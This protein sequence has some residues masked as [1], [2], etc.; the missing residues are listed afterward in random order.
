VD[1]VVTGVRRAALV[2]GG[3]L[4]GLWLDKVIVQLP[5]L[6]RIDVVAYAACGRSADLGNGIAFY[7]V[8]GVVPRC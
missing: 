6:R 3:L 8:V 4:A 7:A 2:A 1:S 5:A